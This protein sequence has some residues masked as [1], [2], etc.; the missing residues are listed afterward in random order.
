MLL[1]NYR[2]FIPG[3]A[4]GKE[5]FAGSPFWNWS[6]GIQSANGESLREDDQL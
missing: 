4:N 3:A 6:L 2:K 5:T 1:T